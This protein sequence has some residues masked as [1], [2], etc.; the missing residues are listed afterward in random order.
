[1]KRIIVDCSTLG[2]AAYYTLGELTNRE[3]RVGVLFGFLKQILTLAKKF[4]STDF[5]FCFDSKTSRRKKIFPEYKIK[6]DFKN[7][8]PEERA[9]K[10]MMKAQLV[11]LRKE[12]L[13]AL[14]FKNIYMKPGMEA[15]DLIAQLCHDFCLNPNC[16]KNT[17]VVSSDHDLH[18]LLN[19][20]TIYSPQKKGLFTDKD[21]KKKWGID[22][23]IWARVK[24]IA[25]CKG[26]GVPGVDRV[27]EKTAIKY[28][29][30]ELKPESKI[31]QKIT[32]LESRRIIRRNT[33]LVSLPLKTMK[34]KKAENHSLKKK[35]FIEVF[36]D[37]Q[38]KTFL[39]SKNLQEWVEAF[40]LK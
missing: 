23:C 17:I 14:G 32:S 5:Y 20:C 15:D 35:T 4:E 31:Y 34:L 8:S 13:P 21:F 29:N 19:I 6:R 33:T 24:S 7:L 36:D 25:G 30:H 10:K 9:E 26:D 11:Q 2:Y 39:K 1:M 40:N 3:K 12:I 37:L 18:Q 27:K 28:L 38:F 22:C 16:K